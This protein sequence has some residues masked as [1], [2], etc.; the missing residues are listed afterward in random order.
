LVCLLPMTPSWSENGTPWSS[1]LSLA[2]RLLGNQCY[3]ETREARNLWSM[4]IIIFPTTS[5]RECYIIS[6][7]PHIIFIF[8]FPGNGARVH[9]IIPNLMSMVAIST[10]AFRNFWR[11][12]VREAMICSSSWLFGRRMSR[13]SLVSIFFPPEKNISKPI[14]SHVWSKYIYIHRSHFLAPSIYYIQFMVFKQMASCSPCC[15][16]KQ[17]WPSFL[18]CD[19]TWILSTS[20]PFP[21]ATT[22]ERITDPRNKL[23]I[24]YLNSG[25]MCSSLSREW[26]TF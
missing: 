11:S 9:Y 2:S 17:P 19:F 18:V 22:G 20:D 12:C 16:H 14:G 8:H 4:I 26:W 13:G 6:Y 21:F 7:H 24:I 25:G 1:S 15:I 3:K 5:R 10:V 23:Y